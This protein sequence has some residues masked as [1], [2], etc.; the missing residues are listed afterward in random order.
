[1]FPD[2]RWLAF[3]A[4]NEQRKPEVW[5]LEIGPGKAYR[6]GPGLRPAWAPQPSGAGGN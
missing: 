3:H 5:V 4:R 6:L 1:M 2:G